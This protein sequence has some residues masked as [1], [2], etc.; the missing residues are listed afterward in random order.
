MMILEHDY[1]VHVAGDIP[2]VV[3]DPPIRACVHFEEG[4][5]VSNSPEFII[6]EEPYGV[7][8]AADSD[9]DHPVCELM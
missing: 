1:F 3:D 9:D 6:E 8:M 5:N 4:F 2:D 7:A